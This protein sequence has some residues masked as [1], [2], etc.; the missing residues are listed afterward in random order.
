MTPNSLPRAFLLPA[1]IFSLAY[2]PMS[3]IA[4]PPIHAAKQVIEHWTPERRAQ[5]IPRD[6]LIDEKGAGYLRLPDGR[7]QPY[8]KPLDPI[9]MG[10]PSGQEDTEAPVVTLLTPATNATVGGSVLFSAQVTDNVS[11]KSVSFTI[12]YPNGIQSQSFTPTYQG[13]D[14]W[15]AN[16]QGFS[17]GLWSWQVVAKDSGPKGGNS[18]TTAPSAF[19]VDTSGGDTGGGTGGDTGGTTDVITNAG[20]ADGGIVK[21]A[22]GRIYFEMPTNKRMNRWAGYVCSGTVAAESAT[23]RSVIIT[24]AHCVFDD[25]NKAFARNVL[26]IPDQD[27]TSGSRTDIDCSNDLYGCWV[28]SFG[29]VDQEW[30]TRTFPDNVAWDYAFYVVPDAGA[31]S[32]S[33]NNN[34]VIVESGSYPL[35]QTVTPMAISFALPFVASEP[36][37]VATEAY[38][39]GLGYSYSDDPNFMYCAEDMTT[40]SAVN[41]W[42]SK[43]DLSGGS[44]GG[45]WVQPMDAAT[46]DGPIISVNSWG[47]TTSPGMAGPVLSGTSASC[48]FDTATIAAFPV[49]PADGAAGVKVNYADCP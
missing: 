25:A 29:V 22:A 5:A 46:G 2:L 33:S 15:S 48:L 13:N 30:T 24:A 11:V 28:P 36:G 7:L 47:Y 9:S 44:S 26:F 34:G 41:W 49:L 20:W 16:L 6:L 40:E 42:L 8:G 18:I 45:P 14:T 21:A 39:H 12:N 43:C 32:N 38:T 27:A 10:K 37:T 3:S 19:T 35:D 23:G 1:A 4:A 31:F 17:D